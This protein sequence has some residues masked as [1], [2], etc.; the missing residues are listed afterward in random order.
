[1]SMKS[2]GPNRQWAAPSYSEFSGRPASS[3]SDQHGTDSPSTTHAKDVSA[4]IP[5]GFE[6]RDAG[7]T[8]I[9]TPV[10]SRPLTQKR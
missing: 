4:Q 3:L 10:R 2:R 1:M 5:S 8:T 9:K 6:A 7:C